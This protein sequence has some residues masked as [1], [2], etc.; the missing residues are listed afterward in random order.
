MTADARGLSIRD[1]TAM[2]AAVS[3]ALN[4]DIQDTNINVGSAWKKAEVRRIKIAEYVKE[5]FE[6]PE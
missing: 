3:N 5:T 1:R 4:V 6:C 2:A